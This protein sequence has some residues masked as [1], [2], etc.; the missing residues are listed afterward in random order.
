MVADA[1][2]PGAVRQ[3]TSTRWPAPTAARASLSTRGSPSGYCA[4]T[5]MEMRSPADLPVGA[6]SLLVPP[7]VP[8]G[9]WSRDPRGRPTSS[10]AG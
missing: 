4:W 1:G 9:E 8:K 10:P 5:T 6:E 7:L 3:I 2:S